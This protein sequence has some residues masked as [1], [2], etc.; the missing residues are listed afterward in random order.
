MIKKLLRVYKWNV[1]T[2]SMVLLLFL[3][4][5]FLVPDPLLRFGSYLVLF[6]LWMVWFV[7]TSVK[8]LGR[9]EESGT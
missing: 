5:Y 6:T 9:R 1:V 2:I 8:Y 7:M 4:T 3:V